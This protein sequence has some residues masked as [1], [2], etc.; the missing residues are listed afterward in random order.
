MAERVPTRLSAKAG[1]K[2]GVTVGVA[3][4]VFAAIAAWRGN[5]WARDALGML[6]LTLTL[7]GLAV[8]TYLGPVERVW[9]TL[10][11]AISKVTTPIIMAVMYLAVLSPIGFLRRTLGGNPMVHSAG[12]L[13]FWKERPAHS[14]RSAS[15]RRQF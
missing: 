12:S 4:L 6:G 5:L 8:P 10:A 9:M 14:R 3:F 2:F 7:A 1:R 15:M 13:G 11:L